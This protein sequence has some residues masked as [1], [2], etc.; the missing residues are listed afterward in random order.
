LEDVFFMVEQ[1]RNASS[2]SA[3]K[4]RILWVVIRVIAVIS[5]LISAFFS[6]GFLNQMSSASNAVP[7]ALTC[8]FYVVIMIGCILIMLR[9]KLAGILLALIGTVAVVVLSVS[10]AV[11]VSF[12]SN[13]EAQMVIAR[14]LTIIPNVILLILTAFAKK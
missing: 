4:S 10:G 7:Y 14:L 8:A 3:G 11:A 5:L 12:G 9:K 1:S 6:L 2:V 13:N